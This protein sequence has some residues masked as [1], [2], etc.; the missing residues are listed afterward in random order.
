MVMPEKVQPGSLADQLLKAEVYDEFAVMMFDQGKGYEDLLEDLEKWGISSSLA[1]LSRFWASQRS[2]WTLRRARQMAEETL[3]LDPAELDEAQKRLVAERVFDLAAS[4]NISEKGILRLREL[5]I[6]A[7]QLRNDARKL[8][9]AERRIKALE[10]QAEAAMRAAQR[11]K[12]AL[13]SGGMDDATRERL[14]AEM[15]HLILGAPK[16]RPA[17]AHQDRA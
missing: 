17:D 16:P 2:Q 5:E 9:Q 13:K 7:E 11:T 8:D 15:D 3:R 6:K 14:I 12:D 1:A 10:D 4:Q